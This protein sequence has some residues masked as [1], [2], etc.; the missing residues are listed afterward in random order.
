[1]LEYACND[2]RYLLPLAQEVEGKLKELGRYEWFLESCKAAQ[3]RV[4]KR[5]GVMKRNP[6]EFLGVVA[7][8]L[9]GLGFCVP[10]G[11]GG[12]VRLLHGT[13]LVLWWLPISN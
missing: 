7:C 6:G 10:F 11:I 8:N 1:M 5:E 4:K 12:T 2:V 9:R 3:T 13:D